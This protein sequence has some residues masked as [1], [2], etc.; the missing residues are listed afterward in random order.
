MPQAS[1]RIVRTDSNQGRFYVIPNP[2]GTSSKYPSVTHILSAIAKPA[3]VQWAA[4]EERTAVS[5]AAADL[6]AD[7]ATHPQLPRSMYTLA[8]EQRASARRTRTPRRSPP[9]P[10]SAPRRTPRSSG[11]CGSR[12]GSAW[13]RSRR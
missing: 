9:R 3:L 6:Y 4:K 8:L 1:S 10:R 12:S 13:A 2:D 5:A 11:R 7:L